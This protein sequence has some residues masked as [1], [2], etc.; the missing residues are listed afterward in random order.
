[1]DRSKIKKFAYKAKRRI[2]AHTDRGIA[3]RWYTYFTVWYF[4][5]TNGYLPGKVDFLPRQI[6]VE[7]FI[8]DC[9]RLEGLFPRLFTG[10]R[11]ALASFPQ[12]L[13]SAQG[14]LM[15][16]AGELEETDWNSVETIGWFYQFF[17]AD[18]QKELLGINKGPVKKAD[19]PVATQLFTP[20]WLVRYMVENSVGRLW[21][22]GNPRH[23]LRSKWLYLIEPLQGSQGFFSEGRLLPENIRILDPACGCGHIL[24]YAFDVLYDIYLADGYAAENIPRLILKNNLSGMDI[25]EHAVSLA[26]FALSIKAAEKKA[27]NLEEELKPDVYAFQEPGGLGDEDIRKFS[28]A[29]GDGPLQKVKDLLDVFSNAKGYGSMLDVAQMDIPFLVRRLAV[30]DPVVASKFAPLVKQAEILA[31]Q[32]HAVITNP[33]YLNR[34]AM[35]KDMKQFVSTNWYDVQADLF[36][37]FMKKCCLMTVAGGYTA[38]MAPFVW[39]FIKSY[40][41][42][43]RFLIDE[44]NISSLVQL[45]YSAFEEATVPIC[46]FVIHNQPGH[47]QG[48]YIRLADFKGAPLQQVKTLAATKNSAVSYR[49]TADTSKFK[50]IPGCPIAYWV[51]DK[52]GA[53]FKTAPPLEQTV[54]P[55]QG[56]AT[57]DNDTF[58]RYWWEVSRDEIAFGCRD[59]QDARDSEKE[60]FP[61]NKGGSYRKWYGNNYHVINWHNNG[62]ELKESPRS[63]IR[64]EAFYFQPGI[65][66]SFVSSARF[67]A[68]ASDTGFLFDVGGSSV[69]PGVE[70]AYYLL[71]FLNSTVA[72]EFLQILN[73]TLNFQVGN[74]A[75]LPLI[76]STNKR[77]KERINQLVRDNIAIVKVDWDSMEVSW[78]FQGHPLIIAGDKETAI[79]EKYHDRVKHIINQLN[80]L[81]QNE[82]ELNELFLDIYRIP[83]RMRHEIAKQEICLAAP[84]KLKEVKSLCSYAVGCILGRFALPARNSYNAA[85]FSVTDGQV[86]LMGKTNGLTDMMAGFDVFLSAVFGRSTLNRNLDFIGRTLGIDEGESSRQRI[87]RYFVKEFYPEHFSLYRKRPIYHLSRDRNDA[88]LTYR[89]G[90]IRN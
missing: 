60:W 13:L 80:R 8:A 66:W 12:A 65:T 55:R 63:V 79:E 7:E 18:R 28:G 86:S 25:D 30:T 77:K 70:D 43:R 73:P 64:N 10:Q 41:K 67:A 20:D 62:Q 1:M 40:E 50:K 14:C 71:A 6:P 90:K 72:A 89:G 88:V 16:L 15:D 36:A 52:I 11:E 4:I 69:F 37:V 83:G 49:Y 35:D 78:D 34:K 57:G 53:V 59:S 17:M 33:P 68:R 84:D 82:Q 38:M 29:G 45:E 9:S 87:R 75:K 46:A 24:V 19:L 85:D 31:S 56:L 23:P 5:R 74:I 39:M 44:H 21:L 42:L 61:Y 76:V 32:Y 58:L 26:S 48:T 47:T 54:P 2:L 81:R 3:L 22:A 51:S 27:R